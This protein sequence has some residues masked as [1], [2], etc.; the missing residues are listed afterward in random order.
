MNWTYIF[1]SY[2]LK[3]QLLQ[4]LQS[5]TVWQVSYEITVRIFCHCLL[6]LKYRILLEHLAFWNEFMFIVIG[7]M[8]ACI[9][10]VVVPLLSECH[11]LRLCCLFICIQM[12]GAYTVTVIS[13]LHQIA[14]IYIYIYITYNLQTAYCRSLLTREWLNFHFMLA[15]YRIFDSL[16]GICANSW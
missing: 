5:V 6:V 2:G 7:S 16:C 8:L 14:Y 11:N 10:I 15:A 13:C 9:V 4:S 1:A 12:S 3:Q